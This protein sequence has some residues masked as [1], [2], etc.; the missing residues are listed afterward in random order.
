MINQN[1]SQNINPTVVAFVTQ[2]Q[3]PG[4]PHVN[5][6]QLPYGLAH[7][8]V[9]DITC[10]DTGAMFS[11]LNGSK[12]S[13][14]YKDMAAGLH[15]VAQNNLVALHYMLPQAPVG[16]NASS[17]GT[18][19]MGGDLRTS[20]ENRVV[21]LACSPITAVLI[22]PLRRVVN[23][24]YTTQQEVSTEPTVFGTPLF[25]RGIG[26]Q[27]FNNT[28]QIHG[29]TLHDTRAV[30]LELTLGADTERQTI[31][32]TALE[33]RVEMAQW[34]MVNQHLPHEH[35]I[36]LSIIKPRG[37]TPRG[38]T[39]DIQPRNTTAGYYGRPMTGE[40]TPTVDTAEQAPTTID[41]TGLFVTGDRPEGRVHKTPVSSYQIVAH[42]NQEPAVEFF[43]EEG[44]MILSAPL[45]RLVLSK[46]RQS[47]K[48]LVV[49]VLKG[50]A[51]ASRRATLIAYAE[52]HGVDALADA[53]KTLR[54]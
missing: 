42:D 46:Y 50:T 10:G 9:D 14:A 24:E 20:V 43:N 38:N 3:Q 39:N 19:P 36:L 6:Q 23:P 21:A 4:H 48:G 51:A 18:N 54:H 31:C 5:P 7:Q 25:M 27:N 41:V 17:M 44:V 28:I 15:V 12:F 11:L 29:Y 26:Q 47:V 2:P 30:E 49:E 1:Q 53:L 34:T 40:P 13:L 22:E 45:S 8:V 32:R 52:K 37:Q 16:M 35:Q 33:W